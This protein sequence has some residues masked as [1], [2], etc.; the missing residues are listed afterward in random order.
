MGQQLIGDNS[1]APRVG[2]AGKQC[3]ATHYF[4][5]TIILSMQRQA[6]ARFEA[7]IVTIDQPSFRIR[8]II[9]H[10]NVCR[11]EISIKHPTSMQLIQ[12]SGKL[13]E[14]PDATT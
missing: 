9:R 14:N 1:K 8:R 3:V 12:R 7:D 4:R 5:R 13:A 6:A 10:K 11:G 2:Q